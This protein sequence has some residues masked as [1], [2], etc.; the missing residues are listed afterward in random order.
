MNKEEEI[1]KAEDVDQ[2]RVEIGHDIHKWVTHAVKSL[3][4]NEVND[5]Q[6]RH[7][8]AKYVDRQRRKLEEF[9]FL[10]ERDASPEMVQWCVLPTADFI[11]EKVDD[12][13]TS[14]PVDDLLEKQTDAANNNPQDALLLGSEAANLHPTIPTLPLM[15][16]MGC[17]STSPHTP[18]VQAMAQQLEE[19]RK[20]QEAIVMKQ[21]Q[22]MEDMKKKI[23]AEVKRK[24][25]QRQKAQKH[26][27]A[28][29]QA[30][31]DDRSQREVAQVRELQQ[32]LAQIG[33]AHV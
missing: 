14:T 26:V 7:R 13:R 15:P 29:A 23:D 2:I 8:M 4:K 5:R 16:E 31:A 10:M 6:I 1:S 25:M 12:L 22:Q 30:Q 27:Q 18:N 3:D 24:E 21:R 32:Q 11:M 33:R 20:E 19:E 9:G 28:Q 17:R